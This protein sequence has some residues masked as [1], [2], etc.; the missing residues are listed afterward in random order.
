MERLTASQEKELLERLDDRYEPT[1]ANRPESTNPALN[2]VAI[3]LLGEARAREFLSVGEA[4][5]AVEADVRRRA[6][7]VGA[8]QTQIRLLWLAVFALLAFC[9]GLWWGA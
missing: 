9:C 8:L 6:A 3:G 7:V 4:M 1:R 2:A 5:D